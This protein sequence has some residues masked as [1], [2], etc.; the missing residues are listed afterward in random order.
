M[1]D[2]RS[3]AVAMKS[4]GLNYHLWV[5]ALPLR[6]HTSPLGPSDISRAGEFIY[7]GLCELW[8]N[9]PDKARCHTRVE[10]RILTIV[11]NQDAK[12]VA[13]VTVTEVIDSMHD[14]DGAKSD[15]TVKALLQSGSNDTLYLSRHCSALSWA[16]LLSSV[17]GV[18]LT[19]HVSSKTVVFI[20]WVLC[21][22]VSCTTP[23]QLVISRYLLLSC[24]TCECSR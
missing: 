15:L 22:G 21:N 7:A 16:T 17:C 6:V 9:S 20:G 19:W 10:T 11:D 4:A 1:L 8:T 13:S 18:G 14:H 23:S 5:E 24:N 3:R 2:T 12:V